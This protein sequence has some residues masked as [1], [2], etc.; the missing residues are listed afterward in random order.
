M[1]FPRHGFT[2]SKKDFV[3]NGG[4]KTR[5][6]RWSIGQTTLVLCL[7]YLIV[8]AIVYIIMTVIALLGGQGAESFWLLLFPIISTVIVA[9]IYPIM[10]GIYNLVAKW[11]GGIEFT[12]EEKE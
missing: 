3:H 10:L 1:K 9:I 8:T 7:N 11:V 12:L 4:M 2:L 5:L 6:S